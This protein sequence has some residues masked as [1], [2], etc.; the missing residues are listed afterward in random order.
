[1]DPGPDEMTRRLAE[2][3][4]AAIAPIQQ[5]L[6]RTFAPAVVLGVDLDPFGQPCLTVDGAAIY[7]VFDLDGDDA[8]VIAVVADA[9]Q[10]T[11][12]DQYARRFWPTC[13]RHGRGLHAVSDGGA[14]VWSC[15]DGPHVV[16]RVGDLDP[17]LLR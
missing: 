12:M 14:A 5:D 13:A 11:L 8:E 1:M 15:S 16:A 10:E 3:F 9:V 4:K 17:Q 2:G 6:D 7:A